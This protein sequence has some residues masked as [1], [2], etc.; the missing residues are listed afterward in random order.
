[1]IL[2]VGIEGNWRI[3]HM[4]TIYA[5]GLRDFALLKEAKENLGV[6]NSEVGTEV[7]GKELV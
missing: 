4:M 1:M 6:E 7:T 2:I 5:K 3:A